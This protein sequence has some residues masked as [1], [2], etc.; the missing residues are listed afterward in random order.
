MTS[1]F[2]IQMIEC[3]RLQFNG[4]KR[5]MASDISSLSARQ[6]KILK[7]LLKKK[8]QKKHGRF[9]QALC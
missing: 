6:I 9:A 2:L 8:C 1:L 7:I 5:N 3:R 4:N